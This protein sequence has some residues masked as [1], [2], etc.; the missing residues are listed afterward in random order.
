M[1]NLKE[2]FEKIKSTHM[3]RRRK[4]Q[5]ENF[6]EYLKTEMKNS[7]YTLITNGCKKNKN[8]I[9]NNKDFKV[10]VMAHYD[11]PNITL[12]MKLGSIIEKI[13]IFAK[14]G[15]NNRYIR[16]GMLAISMFI[17]MG[18]PVIILKP[19]KETY[20]SIYLG[21]LCILFAIGLIQVKTTP[22]KNNYN[23]N[24]SGVLTLLAVADKL[25]NS[26][27]K[28]DV[29]FIFTDNEERGL[30]GSEEIAK[31]KEFDFKNKIII[32]LDCVGNGDTMITSYINAED[33]VN[34][35]I[36][37]LIYKMQKEFNNI[38]IGSHIYKELEDSDYLKFKQGKSISLALMK[39]TRFNYIFPNVHTNKDKVINLS[40]IELI[41]KVIAD[42]I[43]TGSYN[44]D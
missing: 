43:N 25:K 19:I 23:D 30:K 40:F 17:I 9:T 13:N 11:T 41:S 2:T 12:I 3:V 4:K 24:T 26:K 8:M 33:L 10:V 39:K 34:P 15:F 14:F 5:K 27:Y 20:S 28:N 16:I 32:N 6:R 21:I 36:S 18:F 7:E 1:F 31:S 44:L 42:T 35:F 22:N 29:L 38:N 37:A